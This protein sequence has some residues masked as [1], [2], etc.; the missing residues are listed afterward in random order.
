[1]SHFHAYLYGHD[2]H[3]FTDHS[4]VKAVLETPSPSG[5]HAWWWSKIFGS[6]LR[7]IH[8]IYRVGRENAN[9]DALLRCPVGGD[10]SHSSVPDVQ[11]AQVQ[12]GGDIPELLQKPPLASGSGTTT[13]YSQEQEKDPELLELRQFLSQCQLPEDPQ[14]AKKIA[15]QAPSFTL[16]DNIIYFIE[17]KRNDQRRCVVPTHLRAGMMEEN[18]SGPF[19]GHFSGERLYKATGSGHQ[20]M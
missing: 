14:R 2:V 15:A 9:A 7:N 12:I 10:Y 19:A 11:V 18:H 8:I 4:V 3:V 13:Q 20:C 6:G 1:M 16:L 5:K 17:S